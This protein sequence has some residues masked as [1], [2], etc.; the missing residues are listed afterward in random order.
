MPILFSWITYQGVDL[1][2]VDVTT[3]T[4]NAVAATDGAITMGHSDWSCWSSRTPSTSGA[5][6]TR[7]NRA[8]PEKFAGSYRP[9]GQFWSREYKE[10]ARAAGELAVRALH[11]SSR[12]SA[13]ETIWL[14]QT[15]RGPAY[16]AG[17][18]HRSR[19]RASLR[20]TT[21]HGARSQHASLAQTGRFAEQSLDKSG[22]G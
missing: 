8:R 15:Y 16:Q 22:A 5:G 12:S 14:K 2:R 3:L 1:F 18:A 6:T 4:D 9:R 10:Q 17:P 11:S 19:D 13:S 20:P 21:I 7:L